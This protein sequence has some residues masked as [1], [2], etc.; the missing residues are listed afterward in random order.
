MKQTRASPEWNLLRHLLPE[1]EF[2][3]SNPNRANLSPADALER[4]LLKMDE[5]EWKARVSPLERK[6]DGS[7]VTG[8]AIVDEWEKRLAEKTRH[9]E[10]LRAE[11]AKESEKQT[12]L[13]PY[14][15]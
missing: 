14:E 13:N 2:S 7:V 4:V 3:P 8:D 15:R 6:D 1:L 10:E 9:I 5:E 11:H 12:R